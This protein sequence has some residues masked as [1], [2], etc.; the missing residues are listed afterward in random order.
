MKYPYIEKAIEEITRTR[1]TRSPRILNASTLSDEIGSAL[2]KKNM[3]QVA[4]INNALNFVFPSSMPRPL[5]ADG[6]VNARR[7][8]ILISK[9]IDRQLPPRPPG[10][11]A[12]YQ[13]ESWEE[14]QLVEYLET[15]MAEA[16]AP[17][18]AGVY[19]AGSFWAFATEEERAYALAART[20]AI[21]LCTF[22][23]VAANHA[24]RATHVGHARNNLDIYSDLVRLWFGSAPGVAEEARRKLN[25]TLTNLRDKCLCFSYGGS[26]V[27][28]GTKHQEIGFGGAGAKGVAKAIEDETWA[29]V[30]STRSDATRVVFCK[31]F[32]DPKKTKI[33]LKE[34]DIAGMMKD[35]LEMYV[36]RGGTLL[37]EATHKFAGTADVLLSDAVYQHAGF[38]LP[39][40]SGL[41]RVKAYGPKYCRALARAE[42]ESALNNA[43]TY[44]LFCEHAKYHRQQGGR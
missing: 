29:Y 24:A 27:R 1:F 20:E 38:R 2:S 41:A 28:A 5:N 19:L 44:R 35:S 33:S 34:K 40:V 10:G 26:N 14:R 18:G 36:T 7:A 22:G 15:H 23:V 12:A 32:F 4:A 31:M 8:A 6:I 43:D 30:Y 21:E 3:A 13:P 11:S 17:I 9:T 25:L 39:S 42:P 37:H 16:S